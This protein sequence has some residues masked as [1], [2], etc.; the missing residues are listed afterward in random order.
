[1]ESASGAS[2]WTQVGFSSFSTNV[3]TQFVWGDVPGSTRPNDYIPAGF[4]TGNVLTICEG[5][6]VVQYFIAQPVTLQAG[7][8]YQ[9]SFDYN[10]GSFSRAWLEVFIGKTDPLTVT[11]YTDNKVGSLIAWG[12]WQAGTGDGHFNGFY[13]PTTAGTYY[14]VIK[15]GCGWPSTDQSGNGY[16]H[17]SIDNVSLVSNVT[18][19]QKFPVTLKVIDQSNGVVTNKVNDNNETNIFCWI[20]D[21]LKSQNPRNPDDWWY[22][23]YSDVAVVSPNGLLVKTGTAWEWTLTLQATE[24]TYKWN[25][26][27]KTLGWN[28]INPNMYA[29]TGDDGSNLIFDVASDGTITGHP[30][31]VIPPPTSISDNDISGITVSYNNNQITVQGVTDKNAVYVL[32][33]LS[34]QKVKQSASNVIPAA[35]LSSGMYILKVNGNSYK[36]MVK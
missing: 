28:P 26:Y 19:P 13:T 24:G 35:D 34:G 4:G 18:P 9:A 17:S 22:P 10:I 30:E 27:A 15:W 14:F 2:N 3:N 23:M 16:F 31:L 5:W 6:G 8:A 21:N 33:N 7:T 20:S 1:M 11:D 25:P 12:E 29:Y 32:Y 36:V